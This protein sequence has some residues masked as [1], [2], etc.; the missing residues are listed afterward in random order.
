[1][2][3]FN[4]VKAEAAQG[5]Y[6]RAC[7]DAEHDRNK[8]HSLVNTEAKCHYDHHHGDDPNYV[9]D[10][11]GERPDGSRVCFGQPGAW[12]GNAGQEISHPWQTFKLPAGVT[13]RYITAQ[14]AGATNGFMENQFKHEPYVWIVRKNQTCPAGQICTTDYRAL[15]HGAMF[16]PEALTRYHSILIEQRICGNVNDPKTCGIYR[17]G[18]WADFGIL[19]TPTYDGY[20][21]SGV[22]SSQFG[23]PDIEVDLALDQLFFPIY[24][25]GHPDRHR[26]YPPGVDERFRCHNILTD[27]QVQTHI[28]NGESTVLDQWWD[29]DPG[30]IRY[31]V[32]DPIGNTVM[33]GQQAPVDFYCER[34]PATGVAADPN[35]RMNNSKFTA[36]LEYVTSIGETIGY[37]RSYGVHDSNGDGKTDVTREKNKYLDRWGEVGR[38]CTAPG[39]DCVPYVADNIQLNAFDNK[40][41]LYDHHFCVNNSQCP[42]NDHDLT[43]AGRPS[44]VTWFYKH[45]GM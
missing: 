19:M 34:N 9:N 11:C 39:L 24:P 27:A 26:N 21:C 4:Q 14:Q 17:R 29:R 12:F 37:D 5:M 38:N 35:C 1:M 32:F 2:T 6:D 18:G 25:K 16:T 41:G 20:N 44:W 30:R 43:P 15:F 3:R 42:V 23:D 10:L 36:Q 31:L 7:T 40:E 45:A 13:D 33:N 22:G 8:W 28:R